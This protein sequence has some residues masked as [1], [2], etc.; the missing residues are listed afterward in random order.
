MGK[1]YDVCINGRKYVNK[2]SNIQ[3]VVDPG[4]R[5]QPYST[6]EIEQRNK[7]KDVCLNC[8]RK[9][10]TGTKLC[11]EKERKKENAKRCGDEN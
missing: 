11:Y 2:S 10:C 1:H 5:D 9:K 4:E 8:K 7:V 6:E 3:T